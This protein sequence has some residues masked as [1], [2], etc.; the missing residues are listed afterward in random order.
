MC[1]AF[2]REFE[3]IDYGEYENNEEYRAAIN[4]KLRNFG[5]GYLDGLMTQEEAI[6]RASENLK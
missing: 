6:E 1:D 5:E 3:R 4:L 2:E